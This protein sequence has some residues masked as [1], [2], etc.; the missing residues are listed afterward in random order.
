[1]TDEALPSFSLPDNRGWEMVSPI[2]KNGGE[3]QSFG[4]NLGG[5]VIQAAAQGGAFTYTSASSFANAQGA[6]G[7][8]STSRPG[9]ARAGAR[10]T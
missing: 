4:G 8:A 5:G 1:M 6:P 9:A 2:E 7:R 3:I 10:T